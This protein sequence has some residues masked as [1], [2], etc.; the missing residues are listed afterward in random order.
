MES[1]S[2][3]RSR[4]NLRQFLRFGIVG[5]SGTLVNI[6]VSVVSKKIAESG[7]GISEHDAFLNILGSQFHVRWYNVFIT[8][9]FLV[10]NMWNY[11]LNRMW[12]FR[13]ANYR[14]WWRG[15]FP[16]LVAGIGAFLVT[17]VVA[18][19]LMNPQSPIELPASIFDDSTGLRTKYYWANLIGVV[20]AMPMNFM[21]NKLW[22]FRKPKVR[23][24]VES[25]PVS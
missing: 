9:A 19:L 22:T 25:R 13:G 14:S 21:L 23:I 7:F 15:F 8:I 17:Q 10:A 2:A 18:V 5:G 11:Q 12:T 3:M 24:V 20:V 4:T 1:A 16:F 6:A